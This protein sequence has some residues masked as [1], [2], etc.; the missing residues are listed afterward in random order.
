MEKENTGLRTCKYCYW[1]SSKV[2]Y[3]P[4]NVCER[5]TPS[6]IPYAQKHNYMR[7]MREKHVNLDCDKFEKRYR[8]NEM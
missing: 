5:R 7:I 6:H 2:T 4:Y 3:R 1:E 8:Q